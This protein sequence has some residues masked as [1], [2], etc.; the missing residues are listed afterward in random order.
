MGLDLKYINGQTPLDE[1]EKEGLKIETIA[2][3]EELDEFEQN[4]IE[5][6]NM[7][8]LSNKFTIEKIMTEIFIRNLHK[9]MYGKVWSW[10]GKFRT[11]NKNIG[12]DKWQIST[13]LKSLLDDTLFWVEN[14]IYVPDEIAI[15]F[16]HRLVSIHC[17]P[18]GNGRHSRLIA[19]IIIDK[20]YNK[21]VFTWGTQNLVKQSKTRDNYL[22]AVRKAD[23]NDY[24]ELLEFARS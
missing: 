22:I 3:R 19:D 11:T 12:I 14:E 15:R 2:T 7:W 21:S 17:F 8:I 6:A 23:Q 13:A 16:K 1:D 24:I 18:N 10:A 5:E 9:R 20:I 4:N